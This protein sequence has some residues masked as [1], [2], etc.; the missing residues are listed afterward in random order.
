MTYNS[1]KIGSQEWWPAYNSSGADIPA[2]SIVKIIDLKVVQSRFYL[3]VDECDSA[4]NFILG[5]TG[6]QQDMASGSYGDVKPMGGV[7]YCK[8]DTADGTPANEENW[9]PDNGT[10]LLKKNFGGGQYAVIGSDSDVE[11]AVVMHTAAVHRWGKADTAIVEN[12][13]G[14]VSI[15][16]GTGAKSAWVDTE[17]DVTARN[18]SD[19]QADAGSFVWLTY[20]GS[21][22]TLLPLEC[23]A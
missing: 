14:T 23:P 20:K 10:L 19:S 12:A 9:G 13:T 7:F 5:V 3:E 18:L 4:A 17:D 2:A 15:Y 22:W 6:P 16:S 1:G 8:Y 11:I 21:E